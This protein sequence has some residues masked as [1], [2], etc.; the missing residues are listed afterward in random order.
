M[1]RPARLPRAFLRTPIAHRGLHDSDRVENGASAVRAAAEAGYGVEIDVRLSADGQ[2]VVFHDA[3]LERLTGRR[4]PVTALSAAELTRVPLMGSEECIPM[5]DDILAAVAGNVPLLVEIKD[6]TGTMGETDGRLER[7]VAA[8]LSVYSGPLAVM[9]FNPHI[10][11]GMAEATPDVPRGLTTDAFDA[12]DWPS[13]P[14]PVLERLRSIDVDA[15]GATFVSHDWRRLG[16]SG[17]A[18]LREQ[19]VPILSWTVR[20]PAEE[21]RAR[22]LCD[23]VTFENYLPRLRG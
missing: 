20:S 7:A 22:Q 17:L 1:P 3:T 13:V 21:T 9:S 8:T 23:N 12:A 2:P 11:A 16:M 15:A 18:A 14:E 10:V 6:P 5:L 4:D 19:G